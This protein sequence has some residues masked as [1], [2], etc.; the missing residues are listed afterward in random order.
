[1]P[2]ICHGSCAVI[3]HAIHHNG[4]TAYSITFVTNFVVIG[5]IGTTRTAS[6]RALNIIFGHIGRG[7]FVPGHAQARVGI[8]ICTAR[9][10]GNSD[11]ANDFG[12]KFSA[13]GI[14][15]TFTVLDIGPFAVSGHS[16]LQ[17]IEVKAHFTLRTI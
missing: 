10:S 8:G 2:D 4:G 3:G 12:P 14:L 11:L 5:A 6:D 17:F 7:R 15:A 1:M 16:F 13:F 9:P